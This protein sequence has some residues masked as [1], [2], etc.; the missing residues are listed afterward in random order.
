MQLLAAMP[1]RGDEVGLLENHKVLG[2]G[3]TRHVEAVAELAERLPVLIVKPVKQ[4]PP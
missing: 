4:R 3:L 1:D 2:H